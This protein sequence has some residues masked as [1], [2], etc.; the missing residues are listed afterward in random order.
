M[1]Q[2]H[3]LVI[4]LWSVITPVF[5]QSPSSDLSPATEEWKL[6]KESDNIKVY[7]RKSTDSRVNELKLNTV[8]EST[9]SGLVSLLRDVPNYTQWIYKCQNAES[10]GKSTNKEGAYYAELD[11]PWPLQNRDMVVQSRLNQDK[12]TKVVTIHVIGQ[13]SRLKP[14]EGIVRIEV[15]DILWVLTPLP[16]GKVNI[17]YQLLSDPGGMLPAWLI[18]MAI[19]QGPTQTIKG[20]LSEVDKYQSQKLSY[21]EER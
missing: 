10:L 13:P 15:L 12:K 19:D 18:N 6:K 9:L 17:D 8:V 3:A 16:G 14:K 2:F 11:F 7:Y 4:V 20:L 1:K 21:I 5:A